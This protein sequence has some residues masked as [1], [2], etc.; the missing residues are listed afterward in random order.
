[1]KN[2]DNLIFEPIISFCAGGKEIQRCSANYKGIN[3]M[4]ETA[5][6]FNFFK[7]LY[8]HFVLD[9]I[10]KKDN[11]IKNGNVNCNYYTE[12]GFGYPDFENLEDAINYIDSLK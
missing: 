9:I 5:F 1:M 8:N 2:I 7:K 10:V 4:W 3:I 12:S 11:K 6:P